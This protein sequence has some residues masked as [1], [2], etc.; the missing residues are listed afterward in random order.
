MQWSNVIVRM[1]RLVYSISP[2]LLRPD[3][4]VNA[5]KGPNVKQPLRNVGSIGFE[6][7]AGQR[8]ALYSRLPGRPDPHRY[9]TLTLLVRRL[10]ARSESF[11]S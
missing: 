6:Q 3:E 1:L 7:S 8:Q 9:A 4:S 10:Q 2:I 5:V 11:V